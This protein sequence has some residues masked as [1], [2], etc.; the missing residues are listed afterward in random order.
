M[1]EYTRQRIRD[2]I[3]ELESRGCGYTLLVLC[4]SDDSLFELS[5][6]VR[7]NSELGESWND[8]HVLSI[9]NS[10]FEA[11]KYRKK[12]SYID[13]LSVNTDGKE[14]Y[15]KEDVKRMCLRHDASFYVPSLQSLLE[16]PVEIKSELDEF[17]DSFIVV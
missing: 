5:R 9:K 4:D 15:S 6:R 17:F 10:H 3:I 7:E 8:A 12:L 1:I 2:A 11:I 16:S 13:F 14:R